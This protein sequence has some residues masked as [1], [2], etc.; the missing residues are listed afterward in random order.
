[1][2]FKTTTKTIKDHV[3]TVSKAVDIKPSTPALQGLY[4]KIN[5]N[6]NNQTSSKTQVNNKN[7]NRKF[8]G[9]EKDEEIFNIAKDRINNS[10]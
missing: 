3:L 4:I 5:K 7:L 10:K 9:I 2:K 8:I 6:W 1:M